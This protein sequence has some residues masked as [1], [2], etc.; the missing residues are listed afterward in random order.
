MF[1]IGAFTSQWGWGHTLETHNLFI[2]LACT[3]SSLIINERTLFAKQDTPVLIVAFNLA[4][5]R[6]RAFKHTL[7]FELKC[8]SR[9]EEVLTVITESIYSLVLDALIPRI[10]DSQDFVPALRKHS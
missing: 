3:N 10:T 8:L 1:S 5:I 7:T 4:V 9:A 6:I 2:S